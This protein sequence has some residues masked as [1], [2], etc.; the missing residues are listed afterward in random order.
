M[1]LLNRAPTFLGQFGT[2]FV[3]SSF[4]GWLAFVFGICAVGEL[5]CDWL[6]S[7]EEGAL[8]NRRP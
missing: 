8:E 7:L 3:L 2:Y 1:G 5:L 4:Y 6:V